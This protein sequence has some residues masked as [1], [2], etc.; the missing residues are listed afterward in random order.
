[1]VLDSH[2]SNLV[3]PEPA[4]PADGEPEP[5]EPAVPADGEPA[6]PADGEPEPADGE[7]EPADGEADS[8][9]TTVL[10]GGGKKRKSK[11]QSKRKRPKRKTKKLRKRKLRG[12]TVLSPLE[13]TSETGDSNRVLGGSKRRNKNGLKK[14][15]NKGT[16]KVSKW[17]RHVLTY[18]KVNNLPFKVALKSAKKTYKK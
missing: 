9:T 2:D 1:M 14:K 5:A 16:K 4:V 15:F 3:N 6:V 18:A 13:L 17:I 11:K 8:E 12:G 7:P 10:S